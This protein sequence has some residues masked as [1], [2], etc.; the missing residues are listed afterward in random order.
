MRIRTL[1]ISAT[2]VAAASAAQAQSG[3]GLQAMPER[4]MGTVKSVSSDHLTLATEKGDVDLQITPQT[5]VVANESATAAEIAPGAYLGT[6][7]VTTAE[8]GKATEV[9]LMDDGPNVHA[10]MD[11]NAGLMMTNGRVKS[12][13]TTAKGREM[14]VDYG[15]G[16]RHVVVAAD[17]PVTRMAP[18]EFKAL[19]VGADVTAFMRPGADGKRVAAFVVLP[20]APKP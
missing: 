18:A 16:S 4:V 14:D 1:L 2:L 19:K 6:A 7:N 5:R 8:G 20:A 13:T 17:T 12:V 3:A 11:A 10:P 9:H 15:G